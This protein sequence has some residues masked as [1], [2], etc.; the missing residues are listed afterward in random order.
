MTPKPRHL[1][2]ALAQSEAG[3]ALIQ[4]YLAS[5]QAA[6]VIQ[7]ECA[8]IVPDFSAVQS[9]SCDLHGTTLRVNALHPAQVAKLRQA[10]PR[11][12]SRLRLHGLDVI[13][14]KIAVQPRPLSS[15]QRQP[16]MDAPAWAASGDRLR[17]RSDLQIAAAMG[18]AERL[19]LT[20][21]DSPLR[22]AAQRLAASLSPA[23]ARMRDSNQAGREQDAEEHDT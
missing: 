11:M 7:S 13:E 22:S 6:Q 15:S 4:R 8:R 12:L 16:V 9:G 14:I 19:V 20:L 23:L 10:V 3:A 2:D 18:F 21:Q 5:Q 17:R 1:P